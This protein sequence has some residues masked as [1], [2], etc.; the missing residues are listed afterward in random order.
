LTK[1]EKITL[2]SEGLIPKSYE[3]ETSKKDKN[4]V[5]ILCLLACVLVIDR[6][7]VKMQCRE[8]QARI[9]RKKSQGVRTDQNKKKEN[10]TSYH[11]LFLN[12]FPT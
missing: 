7:I 8:S 11:L 4:G 6:K 5:E 10:T 1:K 9:P 3:L 2:K 12:L